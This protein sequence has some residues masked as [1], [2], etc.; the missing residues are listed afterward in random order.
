VPFRRARFFFGGLIVSS[1]QF[2]ISTLLSQYFERNVDDAVEVFAGTL[3]EK[4]FSLSL[5]FFS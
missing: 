5:I 3:T 1:R 2:T 4:Q